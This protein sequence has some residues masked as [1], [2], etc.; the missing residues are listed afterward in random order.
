MEKALIPFGATAEL[1][2]GG[3]KLYDV[4][5][6]WKPVYTVSGSRLVLPALL[7]LGTEPEVA[8]LENFGEKK[9]VQLSLWRP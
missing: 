7:V 5:S 8:T 9:L 1:H 2:Q 4:C 3:V 6:F